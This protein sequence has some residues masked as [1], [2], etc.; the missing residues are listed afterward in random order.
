[1]SKSNI[2]QVEQSGG[3]LRFNRIIELTITDSGIGFNNNIDFSNFTFEDDRKSISH[4][5]IINDGGSN[6]A[7]FVYDALGSSISTTENPA[8]PTTYNGKV[9]PGTPFSK[10]AYDGLAESIG[11]RCASGLSTTVKVLIW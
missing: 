5:T 2:Q 8:V 6:T 10:I 9:Y 7:W 3:Q 11:F 1:M 4:I